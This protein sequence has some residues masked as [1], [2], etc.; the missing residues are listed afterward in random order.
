[1][2]IA[3]EKDFEPAV[4]GSIQMVPGIGDQ[5]LVGATVHTAAAAA[6][7]GGMTDGNGIF[8]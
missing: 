4:M 8:F 1:M 6:A 5:L 7:T 3:L 2:L